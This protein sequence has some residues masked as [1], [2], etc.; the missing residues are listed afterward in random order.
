MKKGDFIIIGAVATALIASVIMLISFSKQGSLVIV[1]QDNKII[2]EVSIDQNQTIDTGTN[3]IIIQYGTVYMQH[4]NCKNQ[5]CINSGK[6]SK[7]G[8]TIVCLPN[9]VIVE[10]K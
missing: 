6:I 7:K 3:M 4:S 8:E 2:C 5:I 1:E 10:I 9:K